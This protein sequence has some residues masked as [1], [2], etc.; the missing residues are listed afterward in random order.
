MITPLVV[1]SLLLTFLSGLCLGLLVGS[2]ITESKLEDLKY[3]LCGDCNRRKES[4][5]VIRVEDVDTIYED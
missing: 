4:A 3:K 5:Q 1:L 2:R